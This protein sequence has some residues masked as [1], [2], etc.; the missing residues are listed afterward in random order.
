MLIAASFSRLA[1]EGGSDEDFL[2]DGMTRGQRLA[3][4]HLQHSG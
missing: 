4:G 3:M 1:G 2:N